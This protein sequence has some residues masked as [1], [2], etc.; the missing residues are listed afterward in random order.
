M[1]VKNIPIFGNTVSPAMRFLSWL[2]D[3]IIIYTSIATTMLVEF[4]FLCPVM[5]D[6]NTSQIPEL[7]FKFGRNIGQR[8][9][10]CKR[11]PG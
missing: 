8:T 9:L 11:R 10:I 2:G 3:S 7:E 1:Q 4:S 5:S 6:L